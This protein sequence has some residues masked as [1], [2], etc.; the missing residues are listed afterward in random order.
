MQNSE[1]NRIIRITDVKYLDEIVALH[2]NAFRNVLSGQTGKLFLRHFYKRIFRQG[3]V[4][5]EISDG[6]V[7]GFV[8][9]MTDDN[10]FY[11]LKYYFWAG[12]G[13]LT[14]IYSP[15]VIRSLVR[16]IRRQMAFR[17]I[18]IKAE[19]LAIAVRE[20][21]RGRGIGISLVNALENH[22]DEMHIP[23]YKVYTDMLF[24]TGSRLYEKLG[25]EFFREVNLF[26]LPFRLYI[27]NIDHKH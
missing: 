4:F 27:K 16:H 22:F 12:L 14:H 9:G 21:M 19:L 26:G 23:V 24:S 20:D 8:A 13:I 2:M 15:A 17:D 1:Q 6:R 7:S 5:G 18:K 11:D 10:S 25:F 3:F